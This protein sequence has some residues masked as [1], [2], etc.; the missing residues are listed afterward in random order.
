[1]KSLLEK[2][3]LYSALPEMRLFWIFLPFLLILSGINYFYLPDFWFLMSSVFFLILAAVIFFNNLRL[4]RSH[5]EIKVERNELQSIILN[6]RDGLVAYD[7]DF[8]VLIFNQA[9]ESIFN[10]KAEEVIGQN[11]SP[12]R[13]KESRFKFLT[14][15]FFPSLAPLVIQRSESGIFPQIIDIS[16]DEPKMELRVT[17]DK[18]IDPAGRLLGFV[19]IVHDRTR[20]V[21]LL[22][23]KSEFITVAAHQLRTPLTAV[24]WSLE[25]LN[26]AK[27]APDEKDLVASGLG[28]SAKLLKTVNDLL[29]VSKIEEGQFG[30]Q[31][32]NTNMVEF[33]EGVIGE[34][35]ELAKQAGI[36][37]YFQKSAESS[38]VISIDPAKLRIALINLLDNAVRYNV[39]NGQVIVALGRVKDEPY[40]EVAIRDTGVG[41][42]PGEISRLFTKFF[43]AENAIKLAPEGS[44]L[45]L[46]IVKNIIRRHGGKIWV[47]SEI[48]RGSTFYFTLPTDPRLIPSKEVVYEEE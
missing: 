33:V 44:G 26:N 10:I 34:A 31:F 1:M 37:I 19:K 20:E 38:I 22:Q 6:L 11:F 4:A 47:E 36:E 16:L 40:I 14:Q 2:F 3:A 28:A 17:T 48:D 24:H 42:P 23:S 12:D 13:A 18:I 7:A 32:E 30:Y 46:Y 9:A 27:L 41:I 39:K 8:K 15:V 35:R 43:R 5:L 25:N 45:G 21:A 29:D